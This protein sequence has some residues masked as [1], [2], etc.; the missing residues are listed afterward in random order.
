MRVINSS[1]TF[2][3]VAAGWLLACDVKRTDSPAAVEPEPVAPPRSER[4][5]G[6]E[7]V[8][9]RGH[10]PEAF[11]GV[12]AQVARRT[13][14]SVVS[15][16]SERTV[17]APRMPFDFFGGRSPFDLFEAPP[18]PRMPERQFRQ[19]GLGSGFLLDEQGHI[20]TNHHVI[21]RASKLRVKL[22]DERELDAEVVGVDPP[23]D[24]AV[25]KLTKKPPPE[26]KP[27]RFGDSDQVQIGEWVAA[28]GAPFGLYESV[29]T[30]IIS[31]MG[32]QHTGIT[33]YGSFLQTDAAINPGNSGGPLVNLD[34][35]VVGINTAIFSQT[36]GYQ[37]V[38]FA[39]P[40]NLA[41]VIADH[42]IKDGKVTRGWI[43]VSIQSI[44]SDMAEALGLDE[45]AGALVGDVLP[46][47]PAA[48]AGL[49]RGDII[50]SVTGEPVRDA[51]D[52]MNRIALLEPESQAE[53]GILRDK[54]RSTL[55]V[56]VGKREDEE[57]RR[58]ALPRPG[59]EEDRALGLSLAPLSPG[60]RR[61]LGLDER[62]AH[63]V[64]VA[65]VD[66]AGAAAEAGLRPGDVVLELNRKP[67]TSADEFRTRLRQ[68]SKDRGV[69]LLVHRGG[70]TFFTV[71]GQ[72]AP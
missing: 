41:K 52:L 33:A 10:G 39:I 32:R 2:A 35:E 34:A 69:L 53:L 28:V 58:E 55:S 23:T 49:Q 17:T 62:V 68:T 27:V 64:V 9:A 1:R 59:A 22:S 4:P 71:I 48:Q 61:H 5:A 26:L 12:F 13:I 21:D 70:S 50:L 46:A 18:H 66:P 6:P 36:G 57:T 38:G 37:G 19:S 29:T 31:A 47:G 72:S 16:V 44:S 24:L 25:V 43:G 8:E 67:V 15:I 40:V 60:M 20:L 51:N 14:P 56:R 3:V 42:L 7:P 45:R 30:G 63:G 54:K 65:K 11:R